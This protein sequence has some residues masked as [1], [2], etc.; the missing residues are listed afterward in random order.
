MSA[1]TGWHGRV[2]GHRPLF[3]AEALE[4]RRLMATVVA[5]NT[6][7]IVFGSGEYPQVPGNYPSDIT[8]AGPAGQAIRKM[9]VTLHGVTYPTPVYLDVV[10]QGPGGRY[11]MVMSDCGWTN[12]ADNL[13]LTFDDD[14]AAS[15]PLFQPLTS[16]TFLPTNQPMFE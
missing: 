8:V 2:M 15:L 12:P 14:A 7:P 16:G 9:T 3:A 5:A 6:D 4:P 13:T 1:G 11:T 10:L